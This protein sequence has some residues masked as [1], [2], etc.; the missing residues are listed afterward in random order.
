MAKVFRAF[1]A[2]KSM[3]GNVRDYIMGQLSNT[4]NEAVKENGRPKNEE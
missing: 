2:L 3:A 1:P 4:G